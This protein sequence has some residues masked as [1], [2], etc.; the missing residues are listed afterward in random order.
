[1]S[2]HH[3]DAE[4]ERHGTNR[5]NGDWVDNILLFIIGSIIPSQHY[6]RGHCKK[7]KKMLWCTSRI[8]FGADPSHF[9]DD[10]AKAVDGSR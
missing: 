5:K 8:V 10:I 1:M 7:E 9:L 3:H 2:C 4:L 6:L